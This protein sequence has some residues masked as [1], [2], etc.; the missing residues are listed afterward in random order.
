MV[1]VAAA[2]R[3]RDVLSW[4]P[5]FDDL[6]TIVRHALAWERKLMARNESGSRRRFGL[7]SSAAIPRPE[8]RTIAR[9]IAN[10]ARTID[11]ARTRCFG[12]AQDAS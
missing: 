4:S 12:L 6:D 5:E 11:A 3:I 9:A 1:S 7:N 2:D 8:V 10:Q